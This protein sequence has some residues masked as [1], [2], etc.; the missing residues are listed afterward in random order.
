[1]PQFSDTCK[2]PCD[3]PPT[4]VCGRTRD[5]QLSS[6]NCVPSKLQPLACRCLSKHVSVCLKMRQTSEHPTIY[7]MP[8]IFSTLTIADHGKNES[9]EIFMGI[10][11]HMFT[12]SSYSFIIT[13]DFNRPRNIKKHRSIAGTNPP[14]N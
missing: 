13:S 4:K 14:C 11:F 5:Q 12:C 7:H 3:H 9:L 10:L 1:M 2:E 8:F 6:R